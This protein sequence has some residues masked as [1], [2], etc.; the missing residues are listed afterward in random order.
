[1]AIGNADFTNKQ[2]A[3]FAWFFNCTDD[4][5]IIEPKLIEYLQ[6]WGTD[7]KL[8]KNESSQSFKIDLAAIEADLRDDPTQIAAVKATLGI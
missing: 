3:G 5:A 6:N 2:K 7:L 4:W 1:M 8:Q